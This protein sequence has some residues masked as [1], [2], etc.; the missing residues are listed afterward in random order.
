MIDDNS[1]IEM[2][3]EEIRQCLVRLLCRLDSIC[4]ENNIQYSL[5]HGTLLGAARHRGFIPWDDDIDVMMTA[6]NYRKFISL[7]CFQSAD[8]NSEIVLLSF[9]NKE[10][11]RCYYPFSK[12]TD[13]MTLIKTKFLRDE[14]GIWIDIFPVTAIPDKP[15]QYR[16]YFIKMQI[17]HRL[18]SASHRYRGNIDW[19]PVTW[20]KQAVCN[21]CY[22]KRFFLT[23]IMKEIAFSV[24]WDSTDLVSVLWG[25]GEKETFSKSLFDRYTELEF[26]GMK[27]MAISKY[28]TYLTSVYE[29]WRELPPVEDQVGHHYYTA[30]KRKT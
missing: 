30:Y 24:P 10:Q 9:E 17:M 5:A 6:E 13:N 2:S 1:L 16:Y 27:F 20:V 28:E 19:N 23:K 29:K 26:E 11:T 7:P 12:L 22:I 21:V 3:V 18:L 14:S 8:K 4:R 15:R 25:Y